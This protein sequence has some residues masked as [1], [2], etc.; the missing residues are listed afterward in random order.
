MRRVCLIPVLCILAWLLGA[1]T[2]QAQATSPPSPRGPSAQPATPAVAAPETPD[3]A[4]TW[5]DRER[6]TGDWGGA[7]DTAERR[8]VTFQIEATGFA[9]DMFAGDG[10]DQAEGGA[11]FDA[12]VNVDTGKLGW[13]DGGGFRTH[14]ESRF[15]DI[16]IFRA[17]ALWPMSTGTS[18]PLGDPNRF[19]LTSIYYTHRFG[20]ATVLMAGRINVIDLL[21]GDPFFG[22]WGAHRF[23]NVA[24]VAPPTGVLPPT[25]VGAI[26]STRR[27]AW[28]FTGMVFDPNDQTNDYW[29]DDLFQDGVNVSLSPGWSGEVGGRTTSLGVTATFSTARGTNLGEILLPP[30]LQ[31][32]DKR[33]SYSVGVQASHLLAESAVLKGR[34]LG[35][36]GRVAV[37]DGNP[38][39][40]Q[41]M[42]SGGL[43]GH[44]M[45]AGRPRDSFGLGYFNYGFSD[46]LAGS[47]QEV[48]PLGTEQGLEVFYNAALTGWLRLTA[49]L[50][51]VSPV[52]KERGTAVIGSLRLNVAF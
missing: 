15:G 35:V 27:G 31:T 51:V 44:G 1:V 7:R 16:P 38:N 23:Q 32:G 25:I 5:V 18:L 41:S 46:E 26:V 49:D 34:G 33:G 9:Q 2:A 17:G 37:G 42:F 50:Q 47:L 20:A 48:L 10:P 21:A 52:R 30:E 19:V 40:I 28:S 45:I 14:L 6:L 29:F 39:P 8:G 11:R 43:S 22:G 4:L 3:P 36:Y 24:F 13:W 12:L